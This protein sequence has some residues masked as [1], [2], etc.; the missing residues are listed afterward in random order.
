MMT[1]IAGLVCCIFLFHAM[2]LPASATG[3]EEESSD[4]YDPNQELAEIWDRL[5]LDAV[6]RQLEQY[7]LQQSVSFTRL[8]AQLMQGNFSGAWLVMKEAVWEG[9]T[10]ELT[11]GKTLMLQLLLIVL[12]GVIFSHLSGTVGNNF[13][14]EN[15]F[16]ITYLILSSILLTSFQITLELVTNVLSELITVIKILIPVYVLALGF[17]GGSFAGAA[18]QNVLLVGIWLVEVVILRVVVPAVRFY[19]VL[20]LVNNVNREDRFSRLAQLVH[21][22]VVWSLKTIVGVMIG[23]NV[24]KAMVAPAMD[25]FSRNSI[26]KVISGLPGGSVFST[27]FTA[28]LAA[29][30]LIQNSIGAAG[31]LLIAILVLVPVVKVAVTMVMV[32]L[33]AALVQPAGEKRYSSLSG[34]LGEGCRL[35]LSALGT[36]VVMFMLSIA[37]IACAGG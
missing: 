14:G 17:T 7:Q 8:S 13:V 12:V 22:M 10:K 9:L 33:T 20:A 5:D 30:K 6:D 3:A 1:W 26:S 2:A 25:S 24:V 4:T 28:F 27:L 37:F 18:M 36:A 16:F 23:M 29:G 31:M 32:K 11:A 19:V 15:G 21:Q 34:I 35:L